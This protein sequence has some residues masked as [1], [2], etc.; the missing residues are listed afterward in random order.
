LL[1]GLGTWPDSCSDVTPFN[2]LCLAK[3]NKYGSAS[4]KCDGYNWPQETLYGGCSA[5]PGGC[6]G[7]DVWGRGGGAVHSS[8]GL[9]VGVV[10]LALQAQTSSN[11]K[12]QV[13]GSVRLSASSSSPFP[14]SAPTLHCVL[15]CAVLCCAVQ[16]VWV[17]P[18]R[19]C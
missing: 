19:S 10:L 18:T 9:G 16:C 3:C 11:E 13:P 4:I 7:M 6:V 2:E 5:T 17:S 14:A 8:C 15:C 12:A 1:E